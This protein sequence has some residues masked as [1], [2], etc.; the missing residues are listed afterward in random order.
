M[1]NVG[2]FLVMTIFLKDIFFNEWKNVKKLSLFV[3]VWPYT[4]VGYKRL[5]N[6]YK[7]AKLIEKENL[8]GSFVECG[9]WRGGC[10]AA[11]AYVSKVENSGRKIWAFDSFQGMPAP[12][13]NDG[14]KAKKY[15]SNDVS[16]KLLP[17][18]RCIGPRKDLEK[19]LFSKLKIDKKNVFI[20]QG[21]FQETVPF[22]KKQIGP[23]AILRLD[24]D[25]YEST[26]VCLENL[27]DNVIRGGYVIIDD[28]GH[29]DGCRKAI[30]EFIDGRNIRV[31]LKKIDYTGRYFQ[32]P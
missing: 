10:I 11:M 30:D 16:G 20:C 3:K 8:S 7:L 21:W 1:D 6:A 12:T 26:R 32:K 17:I 31:E 23:I 22:Y 15:A 24:G 14:E 4:M 2:I 9:V 13:Q 25:W 28:Y 18:S 5:D 19:I 29:W 27:F